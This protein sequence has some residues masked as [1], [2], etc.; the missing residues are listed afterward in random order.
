MIE[1]NAMIGIF[2]GVVGVVGLIILMVIVARKPKGGLNKAYFEKEW[3][4]ITQNIG[5]TNSSMQFAILQADKLLDK[6]LKDSRYKGTTMGERMTAASRAFSK[7]D[8]V[9]SAH[10]LRNKIAHEHNVNVNRKLTQRALVCFKRG[11]K[12]L[13]AL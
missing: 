12:D 1:P 5:D 7:P 9:W 10:K 3:E 13:G 8:A 2:L 11:L 6:A 4:S